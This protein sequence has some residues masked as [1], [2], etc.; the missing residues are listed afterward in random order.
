MYRL[1]RNGKRTDILQF[2]PISKP[3]QI[4]NSKSNTMVTGTTVATVG[5]E[6]QGLSAM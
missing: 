4:I 5:E 3:K 6:I 2:I 1:H